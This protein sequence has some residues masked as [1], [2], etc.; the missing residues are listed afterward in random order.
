MV[1]VVIFTMGEEF[2]AKS[3]IISIL[4]AQYTGTIDTGTIG[5][6]VTVESYG[7]AQ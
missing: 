3:N 5:N 1:G 4:P 6:R 7:R 2:L